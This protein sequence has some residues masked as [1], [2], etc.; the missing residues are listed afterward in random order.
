MNIA[1]LPYPLALDRLSYP[2]RFDWNHSLRSI[3]FHTTMAAKRA[4]APTTRLFPGSW[5]TYPVHSQTVPGAH[6]SISSCPPSA[7]IESPSSSCRRIRTKP[8]RLLRDPQRRRRCRF[9][10]VVDLILVVVNAY[11]YI[12]LE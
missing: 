10:I 6:L 2:F 9:D 11:L 1:N 12:R 4:S 8:R 5:R 3:A 7:K